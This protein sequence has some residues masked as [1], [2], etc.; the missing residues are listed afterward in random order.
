MSIESKKKQRPAIPGSQNETPVFLPRW[1]RRRLKIVA[2]VLL[3]LVLLVALLP[4]IVAHTPL[5]AALIRRA[6]KLDGTITFHSASIGWFS[7]AAVSGI[8]IRDAEGETVLEADRL[9]SDR[10]LLKL[11][12]HRA[13]AGTLRIEKPRIT[14]KWNRDGSNLELIFAHWLAGASGSWSG[15]VDL[16]LEVA[17]GEATI[18]DQETQQSWRVTDLQFALDLWRQLA[19]PTRIEA[20]ATIDDRGRQAGL[21]WKSH[22]K[23]SDAPAADPAACWGLAGTD[24]DISLQATALPLAMFQRLAA[25]AMPGLKCEGALGSNIE[26]QWTSPAN[27][28]LQG[29][30]HGSDLSIESPSLAGDVIRLANVHVACKAGDQDKQLTLEEAKI[31]CDVGNFAASGHIDLG[32]RGWETLAE[33]LRRPDFSAQG[34]LD[35]AKLAKLLRNTARVRPGMEITSGQVQLSMRTTNAAAGSLSAPGPATGAP[36]IAWQA[37]LETGQLMAVDRGRQIFW[38]KPL[39]LEVA[40]H[41]TDQGPIIDS[42]QCRSDFLHIDGRG[43]PDRLTASVALNLQQ[44]TQDLGRFLDLGG[45]VLSGDGKGTFEWARND[46]GDFDSS[47]QIDIRNFQFG[48]PSRQLWAEENLTVV[49]GAKGHADF[50]G[51]TRLDTATAQLRSGGDR[52]DLCL[53]QPVADW[54]VHT[55]W[56][57]NLQMQGSLERWPARFAPPASAPGL[58]LAG[59]YQASGQL[60]FSADALAFRQTKINATQLALT[61]PAWNWSDPAIELNAAGRFDFASS[62]LLLESANLVGSTIALD[63]KDVVCASPGN[64]PVQIDGTVLYQWDKLN[65]LLQP[66]TGTSIQFSGAGTSRFAYRSP[67]PQVLGEGSAA[68]QFTGAN[69]YGFQVGPGDL[70]V[71]LANGI[72]RADPLE[73]T[74]NQGRLALQPELRMDLQPMQ[75]RLSGGTLASQLQLDQAACRSALQYVV[76]VLASVTRSQGRFSIQLEGCRIP[77]GDLNHA[78]VAGRI[79]VHSAEMDPGPL[80]EQLASL[81]SASPA[82]VKIEPESVILFRMTGGRIYHQ[83]LALQFPDVTMRTYGSVGLDDSLKLMVETSVPLKWLPNNAVTDAMRS[84]KLQF[85]VGGTL[86]SPQLDL[87]ELARVKNQLLGNLGVLESELNRLIQPQR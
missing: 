38:D 36:G 58:R 60:V 9:T 42:L 33:G 23:A 83:G 6:A 10:S 3:G 48:A 39:S 69:I 77:I 64:G 79:V 26:A 66:Y 72:L 74:C 57:F 44:L 1:N 47:G 85:P 73:V 46:A 24:G 11:L 4:T 18:V 70:K 16:S 54:N 75:F 53:A 27:L 52:V 2:G 14:V 35:L 87:S 67:S 19:W 59:T 86:K 41:Q 84:R 80:I 40:L 55:P 43:T 49:L 71:H 37:R 81:V 34:A 31:D 12:F 50:V 20:A 5:M 22:L 45:L 61:S 62:R 78:E 51:P 8:E 29:S 68:V 21:V 32:E 17:D 15:G 30:V 63:A 7:S 25:R 65:L 56:L 82:L 76:P 13:N 28:K